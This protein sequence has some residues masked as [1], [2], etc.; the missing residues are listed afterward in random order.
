M[1]CDFFKVFDRFLSSR[2]FQGYLYLKNKIIHHLISTLDFNCAVPQQTLNLRL[3]L[4]FQLHA[5]IT[6][7]LLVGGGGKNDK[8]FT[9][10]FRSKT[11][12]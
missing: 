5:P 11:S 9:A 4:E 8:L 3:L 6:T 1:D 7:K 10:R 2:E 12:S